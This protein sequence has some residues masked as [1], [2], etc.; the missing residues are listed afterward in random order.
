MP[1]APGR[2][3]VNPLS[4]KPNL[5][6]TSKRSHIEY[7]KDSDQTKVKTHTHTHRRADHKQMTT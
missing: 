3:K 5:F 4:R 2:A 7:V 6:Q 1:P